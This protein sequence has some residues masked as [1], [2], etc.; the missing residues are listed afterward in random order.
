MNQQYAKRRQEVMKMMGGGVAIIPT[1]SE[2]IRN[3]DVHYPFRAASDF[4]YLTHFGEPD[5]VA[6]LV[7]GR[8]H[9][10]FI[11]FCREKDP[12]KEIWDG[13]RA[14]LEGAC[15]LYGA[16]DAFPIT[17]IDEIVPGLLENREKVFYCMGA[18]DEFDSRL[19]TW[20]NE[21]RSKARTGITAPAEILDLGHILHEMRL[22]KRC[23]E[24]SLIQKA[25]KISARAHRQAMKVCK[26]GMKEYQIEAEFQYIFRRKG[27]E[28]PA[29]PPIVASGENACILHY[30]ENSSELKDGDLLLIDAGCEVDGYAADISRTFPVNGKFSGEQRALYEVVLAAQ[31]AAIDTIRPGVTWDVPHTAAV[32]ILTEGLVDLGLLR[33]EVNELIESEAYR[34]FYMHK[35]GHWLGMDVHDVGDYKVNDNWRQLECGMVMTVEP[36]LYVREGAAGV[37]ERWWNTGIRIE[38][39]VAVTKKGC[40]VLSK[41]APKQIDEIEAIMR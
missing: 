4:Y 7:P 14:G 35:T 32:R 28:Y 10:E 29:Y 31:L 17:D 11:L 22:I 3:R 19:M 39:D 15:E 5:A 13:K 8:E 12:E 23:E 38:D 2:S 40:E 16:D 20:V 41:D 21:V 9:G 26:P 25:C 27:S 1:A 37:E 6:V 34:E 36:G 30:T 33:G 18:N 24:K